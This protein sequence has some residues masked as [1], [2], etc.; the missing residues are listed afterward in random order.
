V[1]Q[2][3]L[4]LAQTVSTSAGARHV[5]FD[6][7]EPARQLR[8]RIDQD[9]ARISACPRQAVATVLN[10][11]VTG[12]PVTQVRD[13]IYLINVMARATP[14]QRISLSTVRSMQVPLPGGPS[15]SASWRPWITSRNIR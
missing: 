3:A 4:R 14:D 8:I 12:I 5:N 2:I 7:M 1:R 10:A 11:A 15:R 13:D 9:Q 6:W